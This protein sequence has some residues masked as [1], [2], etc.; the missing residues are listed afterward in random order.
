[1]PKIVPPKP[2]VNTILGI[3][4]LPNGACS[5]LSER[6][7]EGLGNHA[8]GTRRVTLRV[9][10]SRNFAVPISSTNTLAWPLRYTTF[11]LSANTAIG[12]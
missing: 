3:N 9:T 10:P 4:S 11:R 1:M 7:W 12:S 2:N 6:Y 5:R 8:S